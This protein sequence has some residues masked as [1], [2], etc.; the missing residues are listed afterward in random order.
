VVP[1]AGTALNVSTVLVG[2]ARGASPWARGC[3]RTRRAVTDALGLVTLV[4]G[5]LNVAR[6]RPRERALPAALPA[7]LTATGGVLLLGVGLR[8][9]ALKA[10]AVGDPLPGP[11][12]APLLAA[13]VDAVR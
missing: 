11:L 1:G 12:A 9:P 5:R 10:V 3:P 7:A 8:L 2:A 4:I 13:V 6:R